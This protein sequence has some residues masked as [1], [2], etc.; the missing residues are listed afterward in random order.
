MFTH[1]YSTVHEAVV[2]SR[3]IQQTLGMGQGHGQ[4]WVIHV[5][6]VRL[7]IQVCQR[8]HVCTCVALQWGSS[9][10]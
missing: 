3:S 6:P 4:A 5:P 8:H 1:L 2:L 10:L 9:D 7:A